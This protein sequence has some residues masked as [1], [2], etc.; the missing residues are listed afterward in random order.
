ML[1]NVS[2]KNYKSIV[3]VSLEL[4]RFN[5]FIGENGAG[6]TNILEALAMLAGATAGRLT[7]EDLVMRGVRVARPSMTVGAF[8]D[9]PPSPAVDLSVIWQGKTRVSWSL[10][11]DQGRWRESSTLRL[12]NIVEQKLGDATDGERAGLLALLES[13]RSRDESIEPVGNIRH[14]LLKRSPELLSDLE[15]N[16][17]LHRL[18]EQYGIY[19]ADTLALRGLQVESHREP[20]GLYGEGLDVAIAQLPEDVRATIAEHARVV[21]WFDGFD[22]DRDGRRKLEG[23]KPGRSRSDLYFVDRFLST[24]NKLFSAENANEGILHL[25]F[26]LVLFC[27]P[28]TPKLFAIDNIETALNPHLLRHLVKTLAE[29]AKAGERQALVTTHN[30]AALDGLNLHDDEQRL[31]VVA[32]NDDGHTAVRRVKVK[33]ESPDG[34]PKFKLSELWMRGML[35]AI[36]S[37]F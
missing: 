12:E 31:F 22:V 8:S 13:L 37:N 23:Q 21:Q 30:P 25:L 11:F 4:G 34:G 10:V 5:V 15:V 2:I 32:R 6:K 27:A 33:P 1:T 26:Y 17:S 20:L 3:D 7:N 28:E 35:G 16:V 29:L 9:T 14:E 24:E 36:P 18:I 19:C